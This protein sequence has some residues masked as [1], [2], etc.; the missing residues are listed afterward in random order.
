MLKPSSENAGATGILAEDSGDL[1]GVGNVVD[2]PSE[3]ALQTAPELILGEGSRDWREELAAKMQSYRTRRKPRSPKYPSL[4]LPFEMPLEKFESFSPASTEA[5]AWSALALEPSLVESEQ[6]DGPQ[7]TPELVPTSCPAETA[8]ATTNLLEF[9][10]YAEAP[11]WSELAEPLIEQPRILDAP[12][13]VP[14]GPALG[15]ILLEA[16]EGSQ[17]LSTQDLPLHPASIS[18]RSLAA[19]VDVAFVG[20]AAVLWGWIFSKITHEIPLRPQMML[21]AAVLFTVL[22]LVYQFLLMV[23][24][25]TTLGL[26]ACCLELVSLDG[27]IPKKKE[28]RWRLLAS[29]LSAASLMLGYTWALLDENRLCWHDRITRTYLRVRER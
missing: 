15:G 20:S 8:S 19:I 25:G 26:R 18:R 21:P 1:A 9:P 7:F 3:G 14:L 29:F 27:P 23:W 12:E 11:S 22:W 17:P 24:S 28:R 2:A 10:R 6:V 16:P 13:L 5:V 4:Q